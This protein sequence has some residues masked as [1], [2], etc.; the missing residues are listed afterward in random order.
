MQP[1]NAVTEAA[2]AQ[3]Q[4]ATRALREGNLPKAAS[5]YQASLAGAESIENFD[6]AGANLLNLALVHQQDRRWTD[7]HAAVDKIIAA[8]GSYGP[9]NAS[10]AAARKAMI[11]LD[12]GNDDAALQWAESAL[13]GC[14]A[15]C[16][17]TATMEN[18]R[19]H[20]AL[21]QNRIDAAIDFASIAVE[22]SAAPAQAPERATAWRLLGRAHTRAGRMAEA[23]PLLA[24]ALALDRQL[25]L[26]ERIALDLLYAGDNEVRGENR[27][28][29]RENYLR[30]AAVAKAASNQ[31]S[32][33]AAQ[34]RL[35]ALKR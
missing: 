10:R 34:A 35:D 3:N 32:M 19:A 28:K 20:V 18:L 8:A 7:A 31:A 13:R 22:A 14:A 24:G 11:L 2:R 1:P 33:R 27:P 25:S 6:L 15:P 21:E 9:A 4:A 5:L 23:A 17:I 12:Q 16:A 26:S 29:A 30:A